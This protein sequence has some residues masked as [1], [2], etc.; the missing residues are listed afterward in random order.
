MSS[1]YEINLASVRSLAATERA[2]DAVS[3]VDNHISQ[4]VAEVPALAQ[5]PAGINLNNTANTTWSIWLSRLLTLMLAFC[6]LGR[7]EV[8]RRRVNSERQ[9]CGRLAS[10]EKRLRLL[11][12]DAL[13]S[14]SLIDADRGVYIDLNERAAV[15][16]GYTREELIG[17]PVEIVAVDADATRA[18]LAEIRGA[19]VGK[20]YRFESVH[21]SKDGREFP[22]E[23]CL[24]VMRIDGAVCFQ[25]AARDISA[26]R[27][28]IERVE[29]T[30]KR[31]ELA[32]RLGRAAVWEQDAAGG[33]FY[34]SGTMKELFGVKA[35][36]Q[37]KVGVF[38]LVHPDDLP[39]VKEAWRAHLAGGPALDI[40][41]RLCVP[42]PEVWVRGYAQ[43][44]CDDDGVP[45]S[46]AGIIFDVTER[47]H[48]EER[49]EQA[50]KAAVEANRAKSD[51]LAMMTHELRTPMNA[52]LGGVE[53]LR[54]DDPL[55]RQRPHLDLIANA[56]RGLMVILDD[57]L[58]MSKIEA[59]KL[60]MCEEPVDLR[61]LFAHMHML[62]TSRA[63]DKGLEL[64][65]ELAANIDDTVITDPSRVQQI[66]S[67]LLSNAIKFTAKGHVCLSAMLATNA[68]GVQELVVA[69]SDTGPGIPEDVQPRLF[70]A[71]EQADASVARR[72][73]GTGLGLA[74]SRRLARALSGDITVS[75]APGAGATFTARVS[76]PT[77][78]ERAPS[79]EPNVEASSQALRI[80]C[81]DDN[82]A[83][84][85]VASTLLQSLGHDVQ[86]AD[87]GV[88]ALVKLGA[89]P[90]DIVL[91]D[92]IMPDL[93]GPE[94]TRRV[95]ASAGPNRGVPIVALTANVAPDQV[96]GYAAAGMDGYIAKPFDVRNLV[97]EIA[98]V[99]AE[100]SAGAADE[101][102]SAVAG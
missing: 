60:Q 12:D 38:D 68:D 80:L 10:S 78:T 91:M 54:R 2:L 16:L 96:A 14:M 44:V 79:H 69:V 75:S 23:I 17:A 13:D 71:F 61:G 77:T 101:D 25:S 95:R 59:G 11:F 15:R 57:F 64:R 3:R 27:A 34:V 67:N 32:L 76:A 6:A 99:M 36:E 100:S 52:V 29:A 83:N 42:G 18:K 87:C 90:Y 19:G 84:R 43:Q 21:R 85:I 20:S 47:K 30:A 35:A 33:E 46:F 94:V 98:R 48:Q 89:A 93:E 66:Y 39:A 97:N 88:D 86:L 7:S 74:I 8:L 9:A 31:L 53:L 70:D 92:V 65:L 41:H 49:L 50:R 58:D 72:F 102:L 73:G 56:G 55:E 26:R 1:L 5:A 82:E 63:E 37:A 62:W 51:F 22:V 45:V 40:D 28:A 4:G 24:N 81:V